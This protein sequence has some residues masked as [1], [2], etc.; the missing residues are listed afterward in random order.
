MLLG[1]FTS[2]I[3]ASAII[4]IKV[5]QQEKPQETQEKAQTPLEK[6]MSEEINYST[7][8]ENGFSVLYP[9]WPDTT[10]GDVELT[11][12]KGYC[13]IAIN[14]EKLPAKQWYEMFVDAVTKQ[15]GDIIISDE[16]DFQLKYSVNFQNNVLVSDN[17][18]FQCNDNSI[19]VTITCMEEVDEVMQKLSDKIYPSASCQEE[20]IEFKDYQ[21]DDFSVNY[22]DWQESSDGGEQRVL[23]VTK[24]ACSVIVDK[25]NAL[26][27]DIFNWISKAIT[28]KEDQTLLS[29]STDKNEYEIVYQFPYQDSTITATTKIFYCNYQS[30]LSQ[31]ICVDEYIT[32]DDE[33]IKESVLESARCAKEYEVPT[34]QKIEEEKEELLEK[35]PEVIEEIEDE[36]VKTNAGEEFGIDEEMVVYFINSNDF[37]TKVMADFPKANLVI[38]DK[39]NDRELKLRV[40]IDDSGKITLLEDGEYSDADV[41]LIVPLR[42]AL[43]IFGNAENINPITLLGFAVNVRTE[44][45]GVKNEVIQK[46][47]RGE[48][49]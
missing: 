33:M 26:P 31:V 29:A 6:L 28:E 42:D 12:S 49:N 21:D 36:I 9:E 17:R 11:V 7:Y 16:D 43:N 8:S 45:V 20:E 39:D 41:K 40:L 2:A 18:I 46:V 27:K 38:E 19:V 22:P 5:T 35:E 4:I 10:K 3:D 23:G 32:D 37:F 14:S 47:L 48:Y 1:T 15:A 44:P 13:T 30:Y 24:G 25:H 34:P